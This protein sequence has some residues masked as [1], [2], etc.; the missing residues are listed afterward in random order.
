MSFY[1]FR[2]PAII[3]SCR[4]RENTGR[5]LNKKSFSDDS[6]FLHQRK[7]SLSIRLHQRISRC[8]EISSY[9]DYLLWNQVNP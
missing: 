3:Y 5:Q 8:S 1:S 6:A 7:L 2:L 9:F 4:L